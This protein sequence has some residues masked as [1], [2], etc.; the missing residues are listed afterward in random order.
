MVY[1]QPIFKEVSQHSEHITVTYLIY[2]MVA[3]IMTSL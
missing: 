2:L 1:L 3:A